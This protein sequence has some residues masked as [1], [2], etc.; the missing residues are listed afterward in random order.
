MQFIKYIGK[1]YTLKRNV[2]SYR[3]L[4]RRS[5]LYKGLKLTY[6]D[7]L[8]THLTT[9]NRYFSSGV[10]A[11]GA[12]SPGGGGGGAGGGAPSELLELFELLLPWCL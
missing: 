2:S 7:I 1:R 4:V 9:D 8:I 6:R 3:K 12:S 11:R 5:T 10:G